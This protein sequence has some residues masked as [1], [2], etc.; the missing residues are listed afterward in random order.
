[1]NDLFGFEELF[2]L[3]WSFGVCVCRPGSTSLSCLSYGGVSAG[4]RAVPHPHYFAS[5]PS[6]FFFVSLFLQRAH[7]VFLLSFFSLTPALLFHSVKVSES[8]ETRGSEDEKGRAPRSQRAFITLY[9]PSCQNSSV[10]VSPLLSYKSS[11]V[12]ESLC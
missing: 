4:G 5:S 11:F 6:T 10:P 1:M 9:R 7:L 2:P 8:A 3:E 12:T